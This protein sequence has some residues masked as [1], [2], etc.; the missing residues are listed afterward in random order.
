MAKIRDPRDWR[1]VKRKTAHI[2]LFSIL[3]KAS[4]PD[5]IFV[6]GSGIWMNLITNDP[7]ITI[8]LEGLVSWDYG[9]DPMGRKHGDDEVESQRRK[10][11][12]IIR[13]EPSVVYFQELNFLSNLLSHGPF[14]I[15]FRE[16]NNLELRTLSICLDFSNEW[17]S[18]WPRWFSNEY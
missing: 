17:R 18:H 6:K 9:R 8:F 5:W 13:E 11:A 15:G 1:F 10:D 12:G 3:W 7:E 14:S 4:F 2:S 16:R